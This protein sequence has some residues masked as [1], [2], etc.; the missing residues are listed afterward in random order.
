M[1]NVRGDRAQAQGT[2][3][4]LGGQGPGCARQVLGGTQGRNEAVDV[5]SKIWRRNIGSLRAK[6]V[7][8]L[9][10][11]GPCSQQRFQSASY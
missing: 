7:F 8:F 4:G 1:H 3:P 11:A 2:G 5:R 6:T 9:R 10:F